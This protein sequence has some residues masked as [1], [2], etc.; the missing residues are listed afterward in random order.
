MFGRVT[1]LHKNIEK[2]AFPAGILRSVNKNDL[3]KK[4]DHNRWKM[5][6]IMWNEYGRGYSEVSQC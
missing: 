2:A 6:T 3:F 1:I 4:N 5:F